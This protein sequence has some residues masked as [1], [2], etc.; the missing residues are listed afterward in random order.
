MEEFSFVF[1]SISI[2][3]DMYELASK[4]RNFAKEEKTNE[5]RK[6]EKKKSN[7][8]FDLVEHTFEDCIVV[9]RVKLF[10]LPFSENSFFRLNFRL[11]GQ[12]YTGKIG[13]STDGNNAALRYAFNVHLCCQH[14]HAHYTHLPQAD[15]LTDSVLSVLLAEII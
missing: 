15:V 3:N 1:Q 4:R 2:A 14:T 10:L 6:E 11:L 8:C 7:M 9:L 13:C 12:S 5:T